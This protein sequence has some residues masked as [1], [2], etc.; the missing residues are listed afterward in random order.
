M[1]QLDDYGAIGNDIHDDTLRFVTRLMPF[2][3]RAVLAL[4]RMEHTRSPS[5]GIM[6]GNNSPLLPMTC[7]LVGSDGLDA[8]TTVL[9]F[10]RL[11]ET[12]TIGH[13]V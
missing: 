13:Y 3:A 7:I 10:S 11:Q 4:F 6:G 5:T 1:C 8:A 2:V 12:N 9:A